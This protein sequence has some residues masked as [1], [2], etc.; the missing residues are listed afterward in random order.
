MSSDYRQFD[1]FD[2][3]ERPKEEKP[4]KFHPIIDELSKDIHNLGIDISN[5]KYEVWDHVPNY[6]KRYNIWLNIKSK[7][8][9]MN[10]DISPI[11]EKYNKKGLEVSLC[12]A[13]SFD[14]YNHKIMLSTLWL[15]KGYKE[16]KIEMVA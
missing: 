15:T 5:E 13:G 16:P 2:F 4:Y 9:T 3:I 14:G 12:S 1:I 11:I 7:E 8:E 10:I 6:G